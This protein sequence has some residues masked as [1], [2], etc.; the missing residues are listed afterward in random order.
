VTQPPTEP[1]IER[2][3]LEQGEIFMSDRPAAVTTLLGSCVA[4]CIHDPVTKRGATCHAMLPNAP[5]V[6]HKEPFRYVDEA[7]LFLLERYRRMEIPPERLVIKLFGGADVLP[8]QS[9][10]YESI[11]RQNTMAALEVLGWQGL[12]A[13]V[14]DT[15]GDR[16]R[17]IVF[18]SHTGEVFLR[19][20][21]PV[22]SRRVAQEE[23]SSA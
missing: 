6:L 16:G 13:S 5:V 3:T 18:M 7:I 17:K 19:R 22:L 15:G 2:F 11:G 9:N 23:R 10:E 14:R 12:R 8:R 21:N 20:L 1:H 4:V